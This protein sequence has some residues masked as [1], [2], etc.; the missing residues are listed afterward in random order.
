MAE[1]MKLSAS[2][3][4]YLLVMEQ[5]DKNGSGVRSVDLASELGVSKPSTHMMLNTLCEMNL[6]RKERRRAAYLTPV[7]SAAA[8]RYR[9]YYEAAFAMLTACTAED[10]STQEAIC[11][12]L[13]ELSENSLERLCNNQK[14]EE[15]TG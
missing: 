11:A 1:K 14:S 8:K 7:G 5:L 4:R 12:L 6:V 9:K 15:K 10:G 2:H 3:I 13:A